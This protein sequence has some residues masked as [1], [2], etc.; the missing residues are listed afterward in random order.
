MTRRACGSDGHLPQPCQWPRA[1]P[2]RPRSRHS[3]VCPNGVAACLWAGAALAG[4]AGL[5]GGWWWRAGRLRRPAHAPLRFA[6]EQLAGGL[7]LAAAVEALA[8]LIRYAITP[9]VLDE[10]R[11]V[12]FPF[13]ADRLLFQ[14]QLLLAE[15]A[16]AWAAGLTLAT[17]AGRWRLDPVGPV[18]PAHLKA[19]RSSLGVLSTVVLWLLPAAALVAVPLSAAHA[20]AAPAAIVVMAAV[21]FALAAPRLRRT[22]HH[23]TQSMRLIFGLVAVVAPLL[24]VYP[25]AALA[26]DRTVRALI[27]HEYAPLT[28]RHPQELRAELARTQQAIDRLTTLPTLV[29]GRPSSETQASYAAFLVWSQ[30]SLLHSRVISDVELYGPDHKLVSRF[31]LNLPVYLYRASTQTWQGT[32]CTWEVLFQNTPFGAESRQMLR[33]ER[34]VCDA[35]GR[36]LGGVVVHVASH[37]YQAL[38]FLSRPARTRRCSEP[39]R[40]RRSRRVYPTFRSSS[41]AGVCSRSSPRAAWRGHSHRSS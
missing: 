19:R 14:G 31:A 23:A 27:E 20:A 3:R 4:V 41:M 24:A 30:T 36:L 7:A 33:A 32:S 26:A 15:L 28:A 17:L 37:D 5:F 35:S 13:D 16:I 9:A 34:G 10:W 25:M 21:V 8:R 1:R 12:L 39:R 11:F 6:A 38:P 29:A 40:R 2:A 18:G 22:Y